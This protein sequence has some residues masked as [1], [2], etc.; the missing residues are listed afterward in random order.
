MSM[1]GAYRHYCQMT[2]QWPKCFGLGIPKFQDWF[3]FLWDC[4]LS[5]EKK[6]PVCCLGTRTMA[7][8]VLGA[9]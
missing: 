3:S 2:G 1:G 9:R 5:L 8:D 6:S 4:S 7:A